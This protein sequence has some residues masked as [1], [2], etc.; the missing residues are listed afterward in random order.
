MLWRWVNGSRLVR[1]PVPLERMAPG[2]PLAVIVAEDARFCTH[3]GV[4]WRELREAYDD[5]DDLS[6]MRGGFTIT[7]QLAKNLFLWGGRSY[8]R[9]ALEF[10]LALWLDL[11]LPK[12][13]VLEIYLNVTECGPNDEFWAEAAARY[14]FSKGHATL[15]P[16]RPRYSPRSRRTRAGAARASRVPRCP[17]S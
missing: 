10:P 7:Q 15:L 3:H 17:G 5:A 2:L 8:V 14:A 6:Q 11:V 13:R 9:K 1:T 12:R 4:D 16:E